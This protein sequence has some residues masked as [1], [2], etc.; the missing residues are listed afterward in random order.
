MDWIYWDAVARLKGG[1][2]AQN[3]QDGEMFFT[4][5]L[6]TFYNWINLLLLHHHSW[7]WEKILNLSMLLW[8]FLRKE[9]NRLKLDT[10]FIGSCW[11]VGTLQ[12]GTSPDLWKKDEC[13]FWLLSKKVWMWFW[14]SEFFAF[15]GMLW[16]VVGEE[17]PH[18]LPFC[19]KD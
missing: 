15:S 6:T 1:Q 8:K 10:R 16:R 17:L 2:R 3:K 4:V 12:E 13:S 7:K 19:F 18:I 14:S 5:Q 11:M 9:K